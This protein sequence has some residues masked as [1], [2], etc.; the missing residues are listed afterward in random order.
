MDALVHCLESFLSTAFNPP[1]DGIALDGLRRACAAT[2]RRRSRTGAT[3]RRRRELLAAALNAGL[4]S[5][6]GSGG[7][8]AAAHGLEA[9]SAVRATACCTVRF[10]RR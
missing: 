4:A 6:K 1:A 8:E 7:I 9:A 2:S 10:C 5:E 3:C